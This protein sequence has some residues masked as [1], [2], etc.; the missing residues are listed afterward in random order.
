MDSIGDD[1][2]CCL[3]CVMPYYAFPLD[4]TLPDRQWRLI[5]PLETGVLCAKCI[6]ARAATLDGAVAVRAVIEAADGGDL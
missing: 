3:D 1:S 2:V 5:H 4:M 6:V